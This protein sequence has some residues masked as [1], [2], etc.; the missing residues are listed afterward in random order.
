M[1]E[2]ADAPYLNALTSTAKPPPSNPGQT[3]LPA[4]P[5]AGPPPVGPRGIINKI[6]GY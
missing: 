6:F 4:P 5:P 3:A 2:E 1:P